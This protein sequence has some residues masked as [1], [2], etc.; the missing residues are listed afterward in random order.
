MLGDYRPRAKRF[1]GAA[2][3]GQQDRSG[4]IQKRVNNTLNE[5]L[6]KFSQGQSDK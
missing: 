6:T 3:C 4:K 5:Q 1:D 2:T